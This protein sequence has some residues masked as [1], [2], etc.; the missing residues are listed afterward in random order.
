MLQ[1]LNLNDPK[2]GIPNDAWRDPRVAPAIGTTAVSTRPMID[3]G[4]V[5]AMA[6]AQ[7]YVAPGAVR[8]RK[9]RGRL[10]RCATTGSGLAQPQRTGNLGV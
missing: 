5:I 7:G 3:T 10:F 4:L 8:R 1:H 9:S 2:R 6:E